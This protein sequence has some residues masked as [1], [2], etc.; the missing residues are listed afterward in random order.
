LWVRDWHILYLVVAG[1][2]LVVPMMKR[3]IANTPRIYDPQHVP[4]ELLG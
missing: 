4:K 1:A 3:V 2:F